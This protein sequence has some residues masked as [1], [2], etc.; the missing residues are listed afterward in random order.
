MSWRGCRTKRPPPAHCGFDLLQAVEQGARGAGEFHFEHGIEECAGVGAG[1]DGLCLV[2][3]RGEK[4]Q[5]DA[6]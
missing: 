2:N 4:G 6:G 5:G 1:A 3:G